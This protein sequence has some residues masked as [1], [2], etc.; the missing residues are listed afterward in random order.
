MKTTKLPETKLRQYLAKNMADHWDMTWHE[1]REITPGVPDLHFVMKGGD[2]RVGWIELKAID[3]NMTKS[4]RI[5]VEPSQHQYMRKWCP[6]M[7]IFFLVRVKDYMFLIPGELSKSLSA[8]SSI[9][10]LVAISDLH[11]QQQSLTTELPQ[12]LRKATRV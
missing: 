4:Q 2:H 3:T 5:G 7:P 9:E 6:R 12:F 11:F 10:D 1:D 8:A